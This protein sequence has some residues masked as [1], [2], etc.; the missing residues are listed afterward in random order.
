MTGYRGVNVYQMITVVGVVAVLVILSI[1]FTK[2]NNEVFVLEE[3]QNEEITES[4][5]VLGVSRNANYFVFDDEILGSLPL[6]GSVDED[7]QTYIDNQNGFEFEVE[8]NF[9]QESGAVA[10]LPF[11]WQERY[12]GSLIN[13]G[14]EMFVVNNNYQTFVSGITYGLGETFITD[15]EVVV[16]PR[17]TGYGDKFVHQAYVDLEEG[18]TLLLELR[19]NTQTYPEELKNYI[20]TIKQV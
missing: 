1:I 5:G 2:G 4:Q 18:K 11:Y 3:I 12:E 15:N 8:D 16:T 7:A 14:V 20:E 9:S 17:T 10:R 13:D 6:Y 19:T